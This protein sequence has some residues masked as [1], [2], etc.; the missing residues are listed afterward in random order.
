[1]ACTSPEGNTV[2]TEGRHHPVAHATSTGSQSC[3][4]SGYLVP[5]YKPSADEVVYAFVPNSTDRVLP[6]H[7]R[8]SE[9]VKTTG[10]TNAVYVPVDARYSGR[11]G[12]SAIR[13]PT[14]VIH[15]GRDVHLPLERAEYPHKIVEPQPTSVTWVNVQS[16]AV[17]EKHD[18]QPK[19]LHVVPTTNLRGEH[20]LS[21]PSN[22]HPGQ[23]R[24]PDMVIKPRQTQSPVVTMA[25]GY[26]PVQNPTHINDPAVSN[27]PGVR[28]SPHGNPSVDTINNP[29]AI[30]VRPRLVPREIVVPYHAGSGNVPIV[31]YIKT[32]VICDKDLVNWTAQNVAEFI[33]A[34]DCSDSAKIFIEEVCLEQRS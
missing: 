26:S 27:G 6:G 4:P 17:R 7:P 5:V 28:S 13:P 3:P 24:E 21:P 19:S 8:P 16:T 15:H 22:P 23:H 18:H 30:Y 29:T 10:G 33:S 20:P 31:E 32:D 34:T 9:V 25:N 12:Y 14:A 11:P 2:R 1:M